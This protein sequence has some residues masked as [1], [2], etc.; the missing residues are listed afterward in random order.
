MDELVIRD[1]DDLIKYCEERYDEEVQ[2][3][4]RIYYVLLYEAPESEAQAEFMINF[5]QDS[6]LR[7]IIYAGLL[8]AIER[9]KCEQQGEEHG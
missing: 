7:R 4:R 5:V 6:R 1:I 3:G 9:G 8:R 2:Y